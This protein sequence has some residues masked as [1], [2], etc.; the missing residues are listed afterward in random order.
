MK[1]SWYHITFKTIISFKVKHK[2]ATKMYHLGKRHIV[3]PIQRRQ[4]QT[5]KDRI[6]YVL[7]TRNRYMEV[8]LW[9]YD[10][11]ASQCIQYDQKLQHQARSNT[12]LLSR[13][14]MESFRQ[15]N[16]QIRKYTKHSCFSNFYDK[17]GWNLLWHRSHQTE[18]KQ[19]VA[20]YLIVKHTR[21]CWTMPHQSSN[22]KEINADRPSS[23]YDISTN[24]GCEKMTTTSI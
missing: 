19:V 23:M 16:K 22:I 15:S 24:N 4:M 1:Q 9:W 13:A 2:A 12:N 8:T 20:S 6:W 14:N 11:T 18:Y 7:R 3:P 5:K 10:H 21:T 17:S